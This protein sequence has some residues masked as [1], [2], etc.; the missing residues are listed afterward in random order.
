M[1]AA[2]TIAALT[3]VSVFAQASVC[4]KAEKLVPSYVPQTICVD[5]L[6]IGDSAGSAF[7]STETFAGSHKALEIVS[8]VRHNEEKAA[9]QAQAVLTKPWEVNCFVG[10]EVNVVISGVVD[11]RENP[12]INPASLS[13]K[14]NYAGGYDSCHN[15]EREESVDYVQVQ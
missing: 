3:F 14:V 6:E 15:P 1:K 13:L 5:S 9:F 11:T 4:F 10:D 12:E 2:F 8:Y 7:I